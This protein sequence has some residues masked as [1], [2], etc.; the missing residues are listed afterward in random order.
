MV[1]RVLHGMLLKV[2]QC[3]QEMSISVGTILQNQMRELIIEHTKLLL[4][5]NSTFCISLLLQ[6]GLLEIS[7]QFTEL[8]SGCFEFIEHTQ[9][10]LLFDTCCCTSS[11]A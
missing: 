5:I 4:K 8:Q 11:K 1:K 3:R 6:T 2:V 9:Q 10:C 7:P